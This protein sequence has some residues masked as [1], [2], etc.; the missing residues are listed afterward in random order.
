[1]NTLEQREI[2]KRKRGYTLFIDWTKIGK[3]FESLEREDIRG[4]IE[5]TRQQLVYLNDMDY[6]YGEHHNLIVNIAKKSYETSILTFKQYK[7][8][9]MFLQ[10]VLQFRNENP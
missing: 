5:L 4:I 3:D 9:R 7:S 1:M 2:V 8:L 10:K 6:N